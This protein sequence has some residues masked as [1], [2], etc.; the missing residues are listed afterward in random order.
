M[1]NAEAQ[2]LINLFNAKVRFSLSSNL[3]SCCRQFTQKFKD[4]LNV[5][6]V[7]VMKLSLDALAALRYRVLITNDRMRRV[8]NGRSYNLFVGSINN[9]QRKLISGCV[10]STV[11]KILNFV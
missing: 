8:L 6:N 5:N 4:S 3:D 2:K 10:T 7:H 1:L 11:S 9:C